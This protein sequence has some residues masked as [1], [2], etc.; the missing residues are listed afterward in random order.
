MANNKAYKSTHSGEEIDAAVDKINSLNISDYYDKAEVDEKL[1]EKIGINEIG[2]DYYNKIE[3]DDQEH[4]ED[5]APPA[6]VSVGNIKVGAKLAGLSLKTILKMMLYGETLHPEF[7]APTFNFSPISKLFG[8]CEARYNLSGVLKF[9]QGKI[10]PA[11]ET[12]GKRAGLPYRYK[13]GDMQVD[14]SDL[15][16]SF[17]YEIAKLLPG[18]NELQLSVLYNEGEQPT[19]S[20]GAPYDK[21]CPAGEMIENV[22]II[23]LTASF[24]GLEDG[25]ITEDQFPTE[26]IPVDDKGYEKM[27]LFGDG[28]ILGYQVATPDIDGDKDQQIV[29]LPEGVEI[30]GIQSWNALACGWQWFYGKTAIETVNSGAWIRSTEMISKEIDGINVNYCKYKFNTEDYGLMG[31]NYFRFFIKVKEVK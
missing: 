21:P 26:L 25:E 6:Q 15:E 14:T 19:D 18:E 20:A 22:K 2:N 10:D 8:I 7:T 16:Y 3:I 12:N 4:F 13:I 31:K 23:G 29:L 1:A 9:D 30:C 28:D 17:N 5:D 24:S 27:G 11:Y